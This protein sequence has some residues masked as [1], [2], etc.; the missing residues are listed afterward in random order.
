MTQPRKPKTLSREEDYRDYEDRNLRDGWP[1]SDGSGSASQ[2]PENRGYGDTAANF[3]EESN[4]DFIIDTADQTGLERAEDH[5]AGPLPTDRIDSDE[6]EAVI[7]ERLEQSGVDIDSIDVRANDGVVT[8]EGSVETI[9][10]ARHLEAIVRSIPGVVEVQN[11]L[12]TTGVDAHI[13]G[14]E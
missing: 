13:P 8:L 7:T 10:L 6:L 4:G 5:T 1:Y 12:R 2:S 14:D 9:P 11:N 3:D